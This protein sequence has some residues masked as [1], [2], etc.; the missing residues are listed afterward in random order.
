MILESDS[1]ENLWPP[2][3]SLKSQSFAHFTKYVVAIFVENP[4]GPPKYIP[5]EMAALRQNLSESSQ[6]KLSLLNR[7]TALAEIMKSDGIIGIIN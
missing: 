3:L 2:S 4:V 1:V 6:L 7:L 5:F